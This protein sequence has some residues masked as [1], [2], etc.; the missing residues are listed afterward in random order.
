MQVA[1]FFYGLHFF[2]SKLGDRK[3][4]VKKG[5]LMV[6]SLTCLALVSGLASA[7]G[8]FCPQECKDWSEI[9]IPRGDTLRIV[10]NGDQEAIAVRLGGVD[11]SL[12]AFRNTHPDV[13][14]YQ[15]CSTGVSTK[16]GWLAGAEFSSCR[17]YYKEVAD[18]LGIPVVLE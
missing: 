3:M 12:L 5:L 18:S 6:I 1:R 10:H 8:Q 15:S 16:I 17:F 2:Q 14:L 7:A 4:V 13:Q 9:E 11:I